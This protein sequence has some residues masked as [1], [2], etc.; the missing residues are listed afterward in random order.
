[1]TKN[2]KVTLVSI[3]VAALVALAA[4]AAVPGLVSV[5]SSFSSAAGM[6]AAPMGGGGGGS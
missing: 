2:I 6:I 4:G 1:M 3:A 5:E